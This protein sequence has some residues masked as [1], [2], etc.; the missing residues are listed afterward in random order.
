MIQSE[1]QV[2]PARG[3]VIAAFAAVYIIWGANYLAIR[4]A[5]ETIPPFFM[6]GARF[7]FAGLMLYFVLRLSG[8]PAP[9][10][11]HWAHAAI[12]GALMLGIGNGALNWAQQKV[13]SSVAALL[14]AVTP[15]WFALLEWL[16]PKGKRPTV[17]TVV[18]LLIGFGGAALLATT[19]DNGQRSIVD[20]AGAAALMAASFCW[21]CG[22][23]YV[24]YTPRPESAILGG[25]L[26]MITGGGMLFVM[27]LFAG[28]AA[29]FDVSKVSTRSI[30]GFSFLL[31]IGSTLGFT[32]YSWLLK[33]STPARISTYAYVNPVV[34]L[35]L[36]CTIGGE[37][38]TPRMLVAA[39][40]V[41]VS[42]IIILTPKRASPTFG[43]IGTVTDTRTIAREC[44]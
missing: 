28:E 35:I 33:A 3:L 44:P 34:A 8:T 19:R 14:I 13:P 9:S 37:T 31:L 15:L 39:G 2:K 20:P 40:I 41:V 24:R 22:S 27:G 36:G 21:A 42:V 26:Q 5:V 17:R 6:G 23:L 11:V 29:L 30:Y 16:R 18:G 25:V 4:Y 1:Q 7:L 12:A 43:Q 10:G 32:S 38:L